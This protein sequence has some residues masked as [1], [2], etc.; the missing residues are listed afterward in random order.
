MAAAVVKEKAE[1]KENM[2][3]NQVEEKTATK[4]AEPEESDLTEEEREALAKKRE[5]EQIG[6]IVER[7]RTQKQMSFL[8]LESDVFDIY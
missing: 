1:D 8:Q 7:A 5:E 4:D 3:V 6:A 2:P